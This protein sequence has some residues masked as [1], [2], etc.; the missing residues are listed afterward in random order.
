VPSGSVIC[1]LQACE[2]SNQAETASN[3]DVHSP[4]TDSV[5]DQIDF[6]DSSLTDDQMATVK[7]F[8]AGWTDVFSHSDTD[9][10]FTSIV[11]HKINLTDSNPFKQRHR[12][13]PPA[14]YQEVQQHLHELLD[15]GVIYHSHSPWASNVVLIRKKDKSLRLCVDYRQLNKRT[16][17]DAYAL[18]RIS[19]ILDNLG[20][21]KYFTVLDMK[22]GYHQIEL[23]EA[24][25]AKTAFTV[26]PLGFYEYHRLPFGL[27]NAP[28]TYQRMMEEVLYGLSPEIC[29][30]Y[31]DD[32]ILVSNT[33][34][35][36]LERLS[37]V[38]SRFREC[39][40]KLS[41]KK[42]AFFKDS[43][44]YVGHIV[45]SNG[46][47]TDPDKLS[48]VV[49]WPTPNNLDDLRQFLGFCWIL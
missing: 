15:A 47:Q 36:H 24:D 49:D 30:I 23:E 43:V 26:G 13:I 10:G 35:D 17:K 11:K 45:S 44:K 40:L 6:N 18:P 37:K 3:I 32:I 25:K 16:I 9:I 31:L 28:A 27:S 33:V 1:Q 34:E 4:E 38:L 39:N 20:G 41:P 22:S 48:K 42:C 14:M 12:K 8:L 2:L 46:V 19:D 7:Q 5:L 29:Q 21:G